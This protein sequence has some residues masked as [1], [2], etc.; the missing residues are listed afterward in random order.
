[1]EAKTS[2]RHPSPAFPFHI[3]GFDFEIECSVVIDCSR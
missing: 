2:D 3:N 1:M